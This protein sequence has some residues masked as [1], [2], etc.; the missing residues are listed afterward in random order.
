MKDKLI[1]LLCLLHTMLWQDI[2]AQGPLPDTVPAQHIIVAVDDAGVGSNNHKLTGGIV[3]DIVVNRLKYNGETDYLSLIKFRFGQDKSSID[4]NYCKLL[5]D[6]PQIYYVFSKFTNGNSDTNWI[7]DRRWQSIPTGNNEDTGWSLLTVSQPY[8]LSEVSRMFNDDLNNNHGNSN[9]RE[10]L[11]ELQRISPRASR[12]YLVLVT[13]HI[14]SKDEIEA[15]AQNQKD[16]GT[17]AIDIDSVQK[18]LTRFNDFYD[19]IHKSADSLKGHDRTMYV[20]LYEYVP[21]L[22]NFHLQNAVQYA[23]ELRASRTKDGNYMVKLTLGSQ[24]NPKYKIDKLEISFGQGEYQQT[25]THDAMIASVTDTFTH[26]IGAGHMGDSTI[27]I[28]AWLQLIDGFY[29]R[30]QLNPEVH[31]TKYQQELEASIHIKFDPEAHL[32]GC[33]SLPFPDWLWLFSNDDQQKAARY[34]SIFLLEL[35]VLAVLAILYLLLS[36]SRTYHPKA[37]EVTVRILKT[38][39]HAPVASQQSSNGQSSRNASHQKLKKVILAVLILFF[40]FDAAYL[41]YDHFADSQDSAAVSE[42][43][44]AQRKGHEKNVNKWVEGIRDKANSNNEE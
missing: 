8:I 35:L 9:K 44:T 40:V 17:K 4:G 12:T 3:K 14:S 21:R 2:L 42:E 41:I 16:K 27:H 1:I 36:S 33:S 37:G 10:N 32:F 23:S 15:L 26:P 6:T 38:K 18:F 13:D 34:T 11:K 19:I 43:V 25:L 30:T 31:G 5:F 39:P 28:K 20:D 29:D 24:D 7:F 22:Q